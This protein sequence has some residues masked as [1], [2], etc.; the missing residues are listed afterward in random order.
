MQPIYEYSHSDGCSI[1]GGFVYRG[2]AIPEL[3]GHFF[4]SDYCAG[5]LRSV[6]RSGNL[7]EWFPAGTFPGTIGF[8]VDES[9]EIYVGTSGGS[10][11]QLVEAGE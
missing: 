1:T 6:D 9:G 10:L 8:G 3:A 2:E 5:W 11:F 7:R 4:F